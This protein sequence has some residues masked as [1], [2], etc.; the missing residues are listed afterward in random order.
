MSGAKE[1]AAD[2]EPEAKVGE[3]GDE[4]VGPVP[5]DTLSEEHV[6]NREAEDVV[7][8]KHE[9]EEGDGREIGKNGAAQIPDESN[10]AT[11]D[12]HEGASVSVEEPVPA[13]EPL[14]MLVPAVRPEGKTNIKVQLVAVRRGEFWMH[15]FWRE[16]W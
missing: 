9:S 7:E 6:G 14:P 10:G 8:E 12:V 5:R 3:S 4:A 1:L 2:P 16:E 13:E 15:A 11:A